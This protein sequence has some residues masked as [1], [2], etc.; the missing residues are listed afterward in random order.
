[1][2]AS[3]V[4]LV[5]N[6]PPADA[7]D[8]RDSGLIPRPDRSPGVRNGNPL[9]F[10]CLENTKDREAWWATIHEVTQS[11]TPLSNWTHTRTLDA[12]KIKQGGF[13]GWTGAELTEPSASCLPRALFP[14]SSNAWD[15]Q[16]LC[17]WAHLKVWVHTS[18]LRCMLKNLSLTPNKHSEWFM[19]SCIERRSL[20]AAS[21]ET[22]GETSVLSHPVGS[23]PLISLSPG[24]VM[25]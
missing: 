11:Q 22:A 16:K 21:A 2:L 9:Q 13:T 1:M 5:V 18:L 8:A 19:S 25:G 15:L 10:S 12:G 17:P 3:Q 23:S 14:E 4:A 7:G 24:P 6:N 20:P